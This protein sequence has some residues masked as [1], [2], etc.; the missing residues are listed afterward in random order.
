MLIITEKNKEG[1]RGLGSM[2]Y[3]LPFYTIAREGLSGEVTF[4]DLRTD[5]GER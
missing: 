5:T 2:L 1:Q 3:G 4:T